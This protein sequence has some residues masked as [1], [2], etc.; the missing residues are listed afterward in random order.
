MILAICDWSVRGGRGGGGGGV[1]VG[2]PSLD[3]YGHVPAGFGFLELF[4]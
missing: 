2:T 4:V 3:F 1:E